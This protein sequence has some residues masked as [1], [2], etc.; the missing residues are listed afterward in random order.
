MVP[1]GW[2]AAEPSDARMMQGMAHFD[3]QDKRQG[4][5]SSQP[6]DAAGSQQTRLPKT[7]GQPAKDRLRKRCHPDINGRHQCQGGIAHPGLL[8]PIGQQDG[9][10]TVEGVH[11]E[12]AVGH[13]I[14][15]GIQE[16]QH[17]LSQ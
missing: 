5:E 3:G 1:T 14:E 9:T 6:Q 15:E 2:K 10:L 17:D 7:I 13:G 11:D 16:Q 4:I 12:M 8:A